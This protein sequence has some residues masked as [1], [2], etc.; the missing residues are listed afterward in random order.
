MTLAPPRYAFEDRLDQWIDRRAAEPVYLDEE[1]GMWR[2]L[3]H[4]TVS[5]VLSEPGLFS[6]DFSGLAPVQEDFEA[7]RSGMFLTMDPPNHRKLRTLVSQ[8][9][10]PRT[11]AGLE[12]RIWQITEQLLDGVAGQSRFDIVD[13]LAY[14][15]PILVIAELLG[16]P[17]QDR[18]LFEKWAKVLFSGD[19]LTE[20]S[21]MAEIEAALEIIAPTIREM[22]EY[23]LAHIRHHR[24]NPSDGL[25]SKLIRASVDGE[26][27]TDQEIVGFVALLLVA[28]HITTTALIGNAT[29]SFDRHPEASAALRADPARIPVA[30]EEV[31]RCLP[32]FNELGRRTTTEVELGGRTIPAN[33]IVMANIASANRD[34]GVFVDAERFDFARNPNPHLTFGHGIHFCLGTPLARMEGRIAFEALHRR[35]SAFSVA[36]NEP[37]EFQNPAMIVSVRH[38]P[39]D[40]E[41]R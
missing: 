37:V 9:F 11:V 39:L 38:L 3:D 34:P 27:L 4:A 31:L 30:L 25:T 35:Y 16:I 15:L 22:N 26:S 18:E 28:G 7:F 2:L 17:A 36:R 14:P 21:T 19:Q 40:V 24:A 12:P 20:T 8:A 41:A 6:S 10:T 29:I 1:N 33:S 13:E 32:P 5:R 23:V